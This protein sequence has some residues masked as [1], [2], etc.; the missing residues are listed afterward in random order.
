MVQQEI[1]DFIVGLGGNQ[2][3]RYLVN[4]EKIFQQ[5]IT[6]AK[7]LIVVKS[8]IVPAANFV[9]NIYQL[10]M[11]G[12]PIRHIFTG[13]KR[14]TYELNTYIQNQERE[15]QLQ[16]ELFV[17]EGANDSVSIRKLSARI[18]AIKDSYKQLS[19]WPLLENGEFGAITEGGISQ[20]DLALSKGGYA[21]LIDKIA[22]KIPDNGMRDA[23][24]YAFVTRDTSLFKALSRATQYGDFLAKAVLYDDLMNRKGMSQTEALAFIQEE[25]VNYNRFAGRN[26]AYLESMGMTWFYNFKLRSMKIGQR[27][28]QNHPVRA[29]L[30]TA[31]TPR[32]PLLGS[33]GNPITD[34][35]LAVIMDG[36]LGYST[37]PGML[38]RAPQLNPWMAII[39]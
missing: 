17:A 35:M 28:L 23:A 1:K 8:V 38:F 18:Q 39:N 11:N 9:T 16:T 24:R 13:F 6:D 19:I 2:A 10:S 29:L 36:R 21:A 12:V 20:E 30:H 27:A 26:R 4:A 7:V 32:L 3:Y 33:I 37:G 15:R 22:N 34:N 25:F 5:V 14:K 31:L